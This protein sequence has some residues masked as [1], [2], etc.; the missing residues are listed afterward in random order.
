MAKSPTSTATQDETAAALDAKDAALF[1]GFSS[2][3]A[4]GEIDSSA[5]VALHKLR[6]MLARM[7]PN[8]PNDTVLYGYGGVIFRTGDLKALFKD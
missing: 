2:E 3:A 1:M 4:S 6:T 5:G 8:T 7:P